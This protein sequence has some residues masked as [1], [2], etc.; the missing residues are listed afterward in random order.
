[1]DSAA[2]RIVQEAITNVLRHA[3]ATKADIELHYG[4]NELT[5]RVSDDGRGGPC[6]EAGFGITGMGER[7]AL[8]GGTLRTGSRGAGGFEVEATLPLG[9]TQ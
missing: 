5:V 1:V 2:H 4:A 3:Q 7:V 9:A 6:N 8:L